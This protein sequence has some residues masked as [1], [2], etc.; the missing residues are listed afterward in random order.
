MSDIFLVT[1]AIYS[2]SG[3]SGQLTP[4]TRIQQTIDTANSIR[5]H[6]PNATI[7]L[8]EGGSNAISFDVRSKFL[9]H[10][11]DVI[12]FS[13]HPFIAFAHERVELD[14]QGI[15]VIKGPCESFMLREACKLLKVTSND[16]IYK[17][18]GRYKLNNK[19]NVVDHH[20]ATGK[21]LMLK[22]KK[23]LEYYDDPTSI[24]YSPFQYS[25]RLYS[26]C[27]SIINK[28]I[29][30]YDNINQRLLWLYSQDKYIDLEHA[31]YL[32]YDSLDIIETP[33]IG[34]S[35]SFAENPEWV[36]EE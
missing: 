14:K 27:G 23:N 11:D 31:T 24:T 19:F 6:L 35:G 17:I 12:D 9:H 10:Y 33:T 20:T 5:K 28:A 13:Y 29:E 26:F 36:I 4:E 22:K 21:Y 7:Y 8:L 30:N 16:R 3:I 2:K 18:S 34:L 1:S 15:T 25:T 32:T